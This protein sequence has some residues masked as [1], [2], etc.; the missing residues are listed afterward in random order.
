MYNTAITFVPIPEKNL[1]F[2][3]TAQGFLLGTVIGMCMGYLTGG[4][5]VI[6]PKKSTQPG[7]TSADISA[8]ITTSEEPSKSMITNI[9]DKNSLE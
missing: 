4:S 9:R 7:T 8:T 3:D 1:R 5:P 6:S 2:A